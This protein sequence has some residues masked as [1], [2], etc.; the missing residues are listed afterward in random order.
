[1]ILE[2]FPSQFSREH[3]PETLV[4]P[5]DMTIF[6]GDLTITLFLHFMQ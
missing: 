5:L 2:S 6:L 3:N 4:R 1:M